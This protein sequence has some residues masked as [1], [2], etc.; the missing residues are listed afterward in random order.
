MT[1]PVNE[2]LCETKHEALMEYLKQ[3]SKTLDLRFEA[4]DKALTLKSEE[5]ERRLEGLNELRAEVIR[6][7]SQ[8]VKQDVYDLGKK[9]RELLA[10]R[11][12]IIETRLIAWTSALAIFFLIIQMAIKVFWK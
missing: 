12:T 3:C 11:V 8:F 7:R 10:T 9:D 4:A 5:M 1:T 6:D 2:K